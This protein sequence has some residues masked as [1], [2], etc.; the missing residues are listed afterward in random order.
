MQARV[1]SFRVTADWLEELDGAYQNTILPRLEQQ[2]GFASQLVFFDA[3]KS[4]A[5]EITLFDS[6]E[7]RDESE[8]DGG[9]LD[10]E[11]DALAEAV[12]AS[13]DIENYELRFIS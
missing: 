3:G 6:E 8:K 7:D 12:G 5:L 13:P 11:L 2:P 1:I 9:L 10:Q 4:R